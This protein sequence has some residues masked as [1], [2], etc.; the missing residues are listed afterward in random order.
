[1]RRLVWLLVLTAVL[2][3]CAVGSGNGAPRET[4]APT[5]VPTEESVPEP[6]A[7]ARALEEQYG[8]T[9]LLGEQCDTEF[10]HFTAQQV[11][12]PEWIGR[13]LQT[14]A[15]ALSQY[16]QGLIQ[17]L[18]YGDIQRVEI[19]LV[20]ALTG[21]GD[22]AAGEY[23]AFTQPEGQVYRMVVDVY[24]NTAA[25]WWHEFSHIIDSRLAYDAAHR[26]GALFSEEA[27]LGFCPE[28]FAYGG[29]YSAWTQGEGDARQREY[30]IDGYAAISPT[31]DRARILE[32]A[33]NGETWY[34]ETYPGLW[35]KLEYYSRCIR[36]CFDT[37]G[38][39]PATLWEQALK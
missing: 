5:T 17:Q 22:Y 28:G 11:T 23:G 6:E 30:F 8:F 29:S 35:L 12:D 18:P 10:D 33:M 32:K 14:L 19:Q 21:T 34:F 9:I 16:P 31:E 13:T 1:M 37:A 24:A 39:P 2:S 36:D 3:G 4:A 20:G 38:W 7:K 25:T 26:P 15:L 27:W